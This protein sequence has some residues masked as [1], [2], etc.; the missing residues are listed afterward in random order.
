MAAA[1]FDR[2]R[3]AALMGDLLRLLRGRPVDLLPLDEV[4]ERL[5]LRSLVERGAQEVQLDSIVGSLGRGRDFSRAF[6]PRSEALR[7][8]WEAVKALA[9]GPRGL[10]PVELYKVGQAY[11]VVDGHHRVSV[12]RALGAPA[13]EARVREY[14]TPAALSPDASLAELLLEQGRADFLQATGLAPESTDEFRTTEPRGYERLLEHV[15]GHRYYRGLELRRPVTWEEA[16]SSWRD[17]VFR[18]MAEAIRGS[19]ILEEFP[20]RTETDLYLFTMD[21]LHHLR[22]RYAPGTVEPAEAVE[23]LLDTQAPSRPPSPRPFRRRRARG[24]KRRA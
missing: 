11:F 1:R 17:A 7:Q 20:G 5:R 23:D 4:R 3:R 10:P 21:H 15:S 13:I 18:P 22:R 8:R 16:V 19:G 2:A 9:E 6:L 24:W 12:A 14:L